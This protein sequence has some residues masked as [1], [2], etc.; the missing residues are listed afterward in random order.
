MATS[1]SYWWIQDGLGPVCFHYW[2]GNLLSSCKFRRFRIIDFV[3]NA[4]LA[5]PL[6]SMV[7]SVWSATVTIEDDSSLSIMLHCEICIVVSNGTI[8]LSF[9]PLQSMKKGPSKY[10]SLLDAF[11]ISFPQNKQC[12]LLS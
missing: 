8:S 1:P 6:V 5:T 9:S 12:V 10:M 4:T 11:T 7:L 2:K 3:S